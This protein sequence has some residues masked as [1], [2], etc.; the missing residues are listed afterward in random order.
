MPATTAALIAACVMLAAASA[1][2]STTALVAAAVFWK[3]LLP[4]CELARQQS[5]HWVRTR[6]CSQMPLPPQS[7]H[8]L[9]CRPAVLA[10]LLRFL[11]GAALSAALPPPRIRD[12]K[13]TF[14]N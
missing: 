3:K 13:R 10:L 2:A 11:F 5:L 12:R 14:N 4:C 7:L 9:R 6:P 8:W 1:V